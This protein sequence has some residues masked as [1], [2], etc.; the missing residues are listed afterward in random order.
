MLACSCDRAAAGDPADGGTLATR[1]LANPA[2]PGRRLIPCVTNGAD[3]GADLQICRAM[4]AEES[5]ETQGA[6]G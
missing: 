1:P 5:D 3:A 6:F 4:R 2:L